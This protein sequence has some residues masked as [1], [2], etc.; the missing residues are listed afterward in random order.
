MLK[1]ISTP[2]SFT[3]AAA[4]G[5]VT[6]R[7]EGRRNPGSQVLYAEFSPITA[8]TACGMEWLNGIKECVSPRTC[9]V[10]DETPNF[11]KSTLRRG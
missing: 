2:L 1:L 3:F 8:W 4:V 9:K 6:T 7:H 11:T 10:G 5:V